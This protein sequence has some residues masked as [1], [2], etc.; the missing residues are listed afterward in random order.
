MREDDHIEPFTWIDTVI[1]IGL[2]LCIA[3][4]AVIAFNLIF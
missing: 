4:G 2:L 1:F 3:F